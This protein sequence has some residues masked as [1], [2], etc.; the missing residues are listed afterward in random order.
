M[1]RPRKPLLFIWKKLFW[2]KIR[3]VLCGLCQKQWFA[4]DL[5]VGR[6]FIELE[7]S[8][9]TPCFAGGGIYI[10]IYSLF[11]FPEELKYCLHF[12][13]DASPV[14]C[15]SHN[16]VLKRVQQRLLYCTVL[17]CTILYCTALYCTVLYCT[18][19]YCTTLYSTVLYSTVQYIALCNTVQYSSVLYCSI[20][21]YIF[22][23][24]FIFFLFFPPKN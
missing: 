7:M 5:E 13:V 19:L 16:S 9:R 10:Y 20:Y 24:L 14:P 6:P 15:L 22:F 2:V 1:L 11:F 4:T 18:V 12:A 17:Y 3:Y 8:S 21:I 23:Y